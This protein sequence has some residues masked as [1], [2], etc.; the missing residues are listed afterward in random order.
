[1]S[2]S[3]FHTLALLLLVSSFIA[4]TNNTEKSGKDIVAQKENPRP[5][6]SFTGKA[7]PLDPKESDR[8]KLHLKGTVKEIRLFQ[9]K[10]NHRAEQQAEIIHTILAFNE[11]GFITSKK[12][13]NPFGKIKR[14][15]AIVYNANNEKI[16]GTVEFQSYDSREEFT[17]TDT[18]AV[19]KTI[20]DGLEK[21]T[22]YLRFNDAGQVVHSTVYTQRDTSTYAYIYDSQNR[23]EE[24]MRFKTLT[25]LQRTVKNKYEY[26]EEGRLSKEI[27][28]AESGRAQENVFSYK[29]GNLHKKENFY[30]GALRSE[31]I[32]TAE[33]N[34]ASVHYH[35]KGERRKT[36]RYSYERD[37]QG[38]WL[39]RQK[40]I[41][42]YKSSTSNYKP[43]VI[44]RRQIDYWE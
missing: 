17:K 21:S 19:I 24:E 40:D 32:Y 34:I 26:D 1:M 44:E 29:N 35:S 2:I 43:S 14:T 28:D 5:S 20:K 23:V 33:E 37:A 9:S 13:Y 38:N 7:I 18:G 4:C 42:S 10:F 11:A 36:D 15:E 6:S 27:L 30:N 3:R 41:K 16:R 12:E 22:A 8:S 39:H 31:T 25:G